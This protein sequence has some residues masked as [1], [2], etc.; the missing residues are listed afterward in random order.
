MWWS[1][2]QEIAVDK[3]L[4][5]KGTCWRSLQVMGVR[6]ERRVGGTPWRSLQEMGMREKQRAKALKDIHYEIML[7]KKGIAW[8]S[9]ERGAEIK[10]NVMIF[11]TRC[12][13]RRETGSTWD[14]TR[15][16]HFE[17]SMGR[18]SS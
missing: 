10:M 14:V 13:K 12:R 9:W 17:G 4:W 15:G 6:E 1:S 2:P 16:C 11:I 3:E 7:E 18:K 8:A 5:V